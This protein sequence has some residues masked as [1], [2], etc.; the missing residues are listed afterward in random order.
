M[1]FDIFRDCQ[2][3]RFDKGNVWWDLHYKIIKCC[4]IGELNHLKM[5]SNNSMRS[6]KYQRNISESLCR[7]IQGSVASVDID[8]MVEDRYR[9][10]YLVFRVV[11]ALIT[12]SSS[13]LFSLS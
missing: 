11:T 3:S 8:K 12:F 5:D 10:R 1:C 9:R 7:I 6:M 13:L 4:D 2:H